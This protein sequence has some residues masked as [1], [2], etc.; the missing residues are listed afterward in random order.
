MIEPGWPKRRR[1]RSRWSE[2]VRGAE[3]PRADEVIRP[4]DSWR[5]DYA[6]CDDAAYE[7]S[8]HDR[9]GDPDR[10]LHRS[11]E[12]FH[13]RSAFA[14]PSFDRATADRSR[15]A[16]SASAQGGDVRRAAA[17]TRAGLRAAR[18]AG[19]AG[20]RRSQ[21]ALI[22]LR[23]RKPRGLRRPRN[24]PRGWLRLDADTVHTEQHLYLQQP[25]YG[26]SYIIGKIQIE[27]MLAA[28]KRQLGDGFAMK[29]FMD[30][31]N[32]IGLIPASLVQWGG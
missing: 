24:T 27:G 16:V 26:T 28:R 15:Y 31:L 32:A 3:A 11:T 14:Q 22:A 5:A 12:A 1:R 4:A 25:A 20:A 30:E 21:D 19:R 29:R 10:D 2:L 8:I 13:L 6:P 17:F 18:T 7:T 9:R 23:S